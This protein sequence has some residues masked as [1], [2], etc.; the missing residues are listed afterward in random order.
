MP[1]PTLQQALDLINAGRAE[2]GVHM[3][4]TV[5]SA[6]DPEA[7]YMLARMTWTG[8]GIPAD[9]HRGRLLFEYAADLGH[10]P[11]NLLATNLLA[12]GIAG[13]RDWPLALERLE[14][15]GRKVPFRL[16]ACELIE[17]MDLDA[18]GDSRYVPEPAR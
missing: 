4:R 14:T 10:G 6:R 7:M 12:S 2:E 3:L 15:E 18:N 9:P 8:N 16:S 1:Q 13:R 11:A 17:A 5:A